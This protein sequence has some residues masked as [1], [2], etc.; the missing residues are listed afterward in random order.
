MNHLGGHAAVGRVS[1]NAATDTLQQFCGES[2]RGVRLASSEHCGQA[3]RIA[4]YCAAAPGRDEMSTLVTT[5][6]TSPSPASGRPPP[7][8]K[9]VMDGPQQVVRSL[10]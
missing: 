3:R 1:Q 8:I 7:L 6:R 9:G 5:N 4:G 10:G 2:T